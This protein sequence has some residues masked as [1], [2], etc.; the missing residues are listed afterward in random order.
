VA[1]RLPAAGTAPLKS[2]SIIRN[3]EVFHTF[4]P[5][6]SFYEFAHDDMEQLHKALLPG[7]GEKPPFAYYY[8]KVEQA[9]GHI[10]WRSPI[11]IDYCDTPPAPVI[12]G[13]K[14]S[15]TSVNE[16]DIDVLVAMSYPLRS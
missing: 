6:D 15:G 11:W 4:H 1:H 16:V 2:I 8:L 14:T 13:R 10:A 7:Q 12:Y 9:D 3:G 5:K